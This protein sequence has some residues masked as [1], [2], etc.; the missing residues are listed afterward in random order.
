MARIRAANDPSR[1]LVCFL[2][3]DGFKSIN[4]RHGHDSGD[5][6]LVHVAQRLRQAV[7]PGD[8]IARFGGD[9]FVVVCEDLDL[10]AA[11]VVT[12]RLETVVSDPVNIDGLTLQIFASVGAVDGLVSDDPDEI[13]AEAD[14][15]MYA[16]KLRRHGQHRPQ[17]LPVSERRDLAHLLRSA[18]DED[19]RGGALRLHF[20]SM[21]QM[22]DGA[23]CGVEA[24]VRWEH[25]AH[26]LLLPAHFLTVADEA[27][28]ASRLGEWVLGEA[29]ATFRRW[30][31]EGIDLSVLA[32]NLA[33]PQLED[34]MLPQVVSDLLTRHGIDAGRLCLEVT[35]SALIEQDGAGGASLA[36]SRLRSLRE[37]GVKLAIDD[38]G[39]GPS[40]LVHVRDLPFDVLKIDPVFVGGI[41]SSRV[42]S[43]VCAAVVALAHATGASVVAEG[44]EHP[45]QHD[46]LHAMGVDSAQGF[47]YGHPSPAADIETMLRSATL[48]CD[49]VDAG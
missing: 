4:D 28:L 40:G 14:D 30:I 37:C 42:D 48:R 20:Q 10:G 17:M 25:P 36:I 39:T 12:R 7:R 13:L 34:A 18:L 11:E 8:F 41:G 23:P 38:F 27:G 3:L 31:D 1:L 43:G 44:V 15:A 29:L 45:R 26:G 32:V 9:E 19:P 2:D 16:A 47:W 35:E 5:R 24:L 21:V 6:M 33:G 22:V 46:L 49:V